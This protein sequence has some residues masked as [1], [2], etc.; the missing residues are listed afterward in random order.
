MLYRA[1]KTCFALFGLTVLWTVALALQSP[2]NVIWSGFLLASLLPIALVALALFLR[3]LET[4]HQS[5]IALLMLGLYA[6]QSNL[7]AIVTYLHFPLDR[8]LIDAQLIALDA[9]LG[10]HWPSAVAW[11][12][13]HPLLA[14]VMAVVYKSSLIQIVLVM[15]ALA[16]MGQSARLMHLVLSGMIAVLITV[17]VWSFWPSFGPSAHF[18]IAP[19][20]AERAHLVV[21]PE[22]GAYLMRIA[23]DGLLA[24]DSHMILG[25]IALPSF[26]TVMMLMVVW[27][28]RGTV[29]I[30][31]VL[32]VNALM[33]P[34][35]AI[36]GGHHV[37]DILA[38][39]A[40]FMLAA[41]ATHALTRADAAALAMERAPDTLAHAKARFELWTAARRPQIG[42]AHRP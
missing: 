22:Y 16:L 32:A 27:Y 29:L 7:I 42:D 10:Y 11:L 40:V 1:E 33:L 4:L 14:R 31:P 39:G 36:H 38:G 13:D 35:I 41:A 5:S 15:A 28:V 17:L 25:A 26:H 8:A 3:R 6:L 20:T 30:W 2:T 18:A 23:E 34:A 37:V 19:E 12:A 24:L 9:T 21:R